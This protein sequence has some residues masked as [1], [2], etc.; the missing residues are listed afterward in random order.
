MEVTVETEVSVAVRGATRSNDACWCGGVLLTPE[1]VALAASISVR[2]VF[3]LIETGSVHFTDDREPR[4]C[5]RSL[6]TIG[7][8]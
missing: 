4:V 8:D 5:S 1:A 3:R 6:R 2:A 7:S